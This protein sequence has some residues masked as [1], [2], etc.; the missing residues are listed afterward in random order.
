MIFAELAPRTPERRPSCSVSSRERLSL[1][2][3]QEMPPAQSA[4][5]WSFRPCHARGQPHVDVEARGEV[6]AGWRR[7]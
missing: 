6:D 3:S 1:S 5:R 4:P 7:R 2:A